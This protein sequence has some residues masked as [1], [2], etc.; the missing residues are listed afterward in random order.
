MWPGLPEAMKR[1]KLGMAGVW[2]ALAIVSLRGEDEGFRQDRFAIGIW[3]DPPADE[4]MD[5][6]YADLAAADFSFVIGGFGARKADEVSRQIAMCAKHGMKAVVPLAGR[7]LAKQPD[8]PAIWG[9]HLGGEPSA[10]GFPKLLEDKEKLATVRPGKLGFIN[11]Y[12]SMAGA[13]RFGVAD[14]QT[15]L[16]EFCKTVRPEVLCGHHYP[17]FSPQRDEREGYH[18]TLGL[19]REQG[20]ELD[21]PFWNFFEAMPSSSGEDPT[22]AQLR[23]QVFTSLTYGAKGV[24]Y[25]CY[26]TPKSKSGPALITHDGSKSRHYHEA[27]R[28]NRRVSHLGPTLLELDS[29][30]VVRI[31]AEDDAVALLAGQPVSILSKGEYLVGVFRHAGGGQAVMIH[32]Q[33][34]AYS[35]SPTLSFAA[36]RVHEISQESGAEVAVTDEDRGR[37]GLQ[38]RL[39]AGE[40]RLFLTRP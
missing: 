9:Y 11:L 18:Q 2:L 14:F 37:D 38:I 32:N 17:R 35:A 40:G 28:I 20:L 7:P 13:K 23:W 22:E 34:Y 25:H 24:M 36:D 33:S 26:W 10:S 16:T 8:D 15:Y 27:A 39:D 31:R 6:S 30:A 1:F 29:T 4:R 3:V 21:V 5:Q 19:F 12:P